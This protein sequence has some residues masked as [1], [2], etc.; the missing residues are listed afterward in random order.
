MMLQYHSFIEYS[1]PK[2]ENFERQLDTI[3]G[4][5]QSFFNVEL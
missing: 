5:K 1:C 2:L 4:D 3:N